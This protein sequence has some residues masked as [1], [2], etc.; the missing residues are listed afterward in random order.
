MDFLSRYPRSLPFVVIAML[1]KMYLWGFSLLQIF[2]TVFPIVT[3]RP[4]EG[5]VPT[6]DAPCPVAA[7]EMEFLPLMLTSV[8]CA[9]GLTWAFLRLAVIY[10][11]QE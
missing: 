4:Q 11:W 1:E 8:Y 10:L 9:V 7:A 5:C 2:V 6:K 3:R